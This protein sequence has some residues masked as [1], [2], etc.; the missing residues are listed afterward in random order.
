MAFQSDDR[1]STALRNAIPSVKGASALF[2]MVIAHLGER[3]VVETSGSKESGRTKVLHVRAGGDGSLV[4]PWPLLSLAIADPAILDEFA[5]GSE[6]VAGPAPLPAS[7][8]IELTG[9]FHPVP[10]TLTLHDGPEALSVNYRRD[11]RWQDTSEG[12]APAPFAALSIALACSTAAP[13]ELLAAYVASIDLG[14]H[15]PARVWM[16]APQPGGVDG[17]W[18]AARGAIREAVEAGRAPRGA[19]WAVADGYTGSAIAFGPSRETA[20]TAWRAEVERVRPAPPEPTAADPDDEP[21]G[22][23]P[24]WDS[25][26]AHELEGAMEFRV[27]GFDVPPFDPSPKATPAAVLPIAAVPGPAPSTGELTRWIGA[28]GTT[29]FA[30]RLSRDDRF[31][32]VG[33]GMLPRIDL[34][35]LDTTLNRLNRQLPSA[36]MRADF[37]AR[38]GVELTHCIAYYRCV[39]ERTGAPTKPAITQSNVTT[40]FDVRSF[41]GDTL[42]WAIVRVLRYDA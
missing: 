33:V 36:A 38:T 10:A 16:P 5:A 27:R 2:D 26:P 23:A 8:F 20:M 22:A 37:E 15:G 12:F 24:K 11:G 9:A 1:P 4:I 32:L 34:A 42:R 13:L 19:T 6:S 31:T 41:D 30:V 35:T 40:H 39:D 18:L 7:G 25:G 29:Q 3:A 21:D 28:R 14:R 17:V